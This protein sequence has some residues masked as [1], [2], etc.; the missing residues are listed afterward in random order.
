MPIWQEVAERA[1][2]KSMEGQGTVEHAQGCQGPGE[3]AGAS[4]TA[5][6]RAKGTEEG[7]KGNKCFVYPLIDRN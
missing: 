4:E 6:E 2:G 3:A 5:V 1:E 7:R